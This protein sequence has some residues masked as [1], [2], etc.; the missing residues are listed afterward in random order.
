M[1]FTSPGHPIHH[2]PTTPG[3]GLGQKLSELAAFHQSWVGKG[4]GRWVRWGSLNQVVLTLPNWC[5]NMLFFVGMDIKIM[6]S[7][8]FKWHVGWWQMNSH[9]F[10]PPTIFQVETVQ[11]KTTLFGRT[12]STVVNKI[13]DKDC[14]KHDFAETTSNLVDALWFSS[15]VDL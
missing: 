14:D 6:V 3:H 8:F 4:R 9:L 5:K 10:F 7:C 2:P 1:I 11:V 15:L 12:S 13:I